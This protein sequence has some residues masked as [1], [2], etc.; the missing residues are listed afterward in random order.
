MASQDK[1]KIP[2]PASTWGSFGAF[3]RQLRFQRNLSLREVAAIAG[4]DQA[5]LSKAELGQ[6]FPTARQTMALARFFQHDAVEFEA[7]CI[8]EKFRQRHG[9]SAAALR[10][11]LILQGDETME[12][13]EP[14]KASSRPPPLPI[15]DDPVEDSPRVIILHA[16]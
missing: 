8:A 5:H 4:M 6:R 14:I 11:V 7:R 9:G 10:A 16:D 1:Y 13:R 12:A 3:L 15:E 2:V